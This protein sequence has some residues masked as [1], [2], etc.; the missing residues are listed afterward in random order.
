MESRIEVP[1]YDASSRQVVGQ[2]L[3][4]LYLFGV[5]LDIEDQDYV[6]HF[7]TEASNPGPFLRR[8][9][10]YMDLQ[11]STTKW[12]LGGSGIAGPFWLDL[13]FGQDPFF[14]S[15]QNNAIA[16]SS[17][18]NHNAS[19]PANAVNPKFTWDAWI[20]KCNS[21]TPSGLFGCDCPSQADWNQHN[22]FANWTDAQYRNLSDG[23]LPYIAPLGG[24][25]GKYVYR[26]SSPN[27]TQ[28]GKADGGTTPDDPTHTDGRS[29]TSYL[30]FTFALDYDIINLSCNLG[31]GFRSG[32]ELSQGSYYANEFASHYANVV[33]SL[34]AESNASLDVR[35]IIRNPFLFGPATLFDGT[36]TI[37]D[38]T[39]V[40]RYQHVNAAQISYDFANGF[41]F[42][43][44]NT[45]STGNVPAPAAHDSC[46]AVPAS[47]NP[48]VQPQS[49]QDFLQQATQAAKN[50]LFPCHVA[51]CS[52][53]S[54][55]AQIGKLRTCQWNR[56]TQKLDCVQTTQSCTVCTQ[57]TADLCDAAGNVYH[58]TSG[59]HPGLNCPLQ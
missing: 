47:N 15:M 31:V 2:R 19:D 53:D 13:D 52:I 57:Q 11:T 48:T 29:P 43:Q 38:P 7:P 40:K 54:A 35:L 41:P 28:L 8:T 14:R 12:E 51:L 56:S 25:S 4:K 17:L 39:K 23:I 27:W 33:T 37:L 1:K 49:P 46:L 9:G 5:G 20:N 50:E 45:A 18:D 30:N 55:N 21:C 24:V 16:F 22:Y 42:S 32:M 58:A 36:F 6:A 59:S 44:Y 26:D 34:E 10:Y 3:G